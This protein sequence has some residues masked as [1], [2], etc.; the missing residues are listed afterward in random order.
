MATSGLGLLG[1]PTALTLGCPAPHVRTAH[2]HRPTASDGS[3]RNAWEL[4]RKEGTTYPKGGGASMWLA[5]EQ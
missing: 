3:E 2:L 1:D 5:K 4:P